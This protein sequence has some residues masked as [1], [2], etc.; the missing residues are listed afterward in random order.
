MNAAHPQPP[1]AVRSALVA[2]FAW[3]GDRTDRWGIANTTGWW[4][5]AHLLAALG[6]ALGALYPEASPTVVVGPQSR[7]FLLGALTAA[8][9]GVGF[10]EARKHGHAAADSDAWLRRTSP[11]DYRDRHVRFG[12]RKNLV[13]AGDR[14]L[15]V[16]DWVD[17]GATAVTIKALVEDSGAE[18]VGVAAIV[19]ALED[20]G[21]RRRLPLRT[22]LHHREL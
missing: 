12:F 6:P 8:A 4:R 22:L 14:V 21:L 18:W 19:D 11:P 2:E 17:T 7:G 15:M 5:D 3:L 20:G 9:L 16:D 10:V 1:G 13:R